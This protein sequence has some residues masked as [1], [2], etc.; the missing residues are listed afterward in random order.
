MWAGY[1]GDQ[2]MVLLVAEDM[3]K[4]SLLLGGKRILTFSMNTA[5]DVPLENLFLQCHEEGVGS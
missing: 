5:A 4:L 3:S 1:N 2:T